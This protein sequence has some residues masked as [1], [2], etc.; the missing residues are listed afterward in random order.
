MP[1][2]EGRDRYI[3]ISYYFTPRFLL[4]SLIYFPNSTVPSLTTLSHSPF[5]TPTHFCTNEV[6]LSSLWTL[7]LLQK[8]LLTQICPYHFSVQ[9]YLSLIYHSTPKIWSTF[10][11]PYFSEWHYHPSTGISPTLRYH[12]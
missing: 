7:S 5:K 11:L 1:G 9:L 3:Y 2:T 12:P 4:L 6:E 10:T 8:P